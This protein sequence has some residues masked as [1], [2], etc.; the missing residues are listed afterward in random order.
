MKTDNF[1][2]KNRI[3]QLILINLFKKNILLFFLI[4]NFS[5]SSFGIENS[6]LKKVTTVPMF[7]LK[8]A[9]LPNY[10]DECLFYY[11][12]GATNGFDSDYD[13]YK[14]FGPNPA[15]HISIDND[16]LLLVINGIPPVVQSYSTMILTTTNITGSYTITAADVQGLPLGTCVFLK[17]LMTNT[18]TN[19]LLNSYVFNLSNTATTSRFVLTI[20]YNTMP[21]VSSI[22]QPLCNN[23]TAGKFKLAAS[24]NG[25]MN[26][27]WKDTSGNVIK[28]SLGLNSSDSLY[29]LTNGT[30]QVEITS[31]NDAC[32]RNE[33][34][35]NITSVIVPTVNF[36]YSNNIVAGTPSN[37]SPINLSVN[38][39]NYLWNFGDAVGCSNLIQNTYCYSNAGLYQ[40]KL[41][42]IS[43]SGCSDSVTK[44]VEV[45]SL[46]TFIKTIELDGLEIFN[47]G[48]NSYLV[49]AN[50][51]L[52]KELTVSLYNLKGEVVVTESLNNRN[53]MK[54]NFDNLSAE[55]YMLDVLLNNS[56]HR[57]SKVIIQ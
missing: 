25:A 13:A 45:I 14:I 4:L 1:T 51:T 43:N 55:I 56:I 11:Q 26:Y 22:N 44:T 53:E 5:T 30:Y 36:S 23:P 57:T 54:L 29:N 33:V 15:P 42:G 27:N 8:M 38:C 3:V 49:R 32:L 2:S 31:V 20:T 21:I 9:G 16:S 40:V 28:T 24:V 12:V 41:V 10:L 17:D 6:S 47:T 19:L 35:F 37:F 39:S 7:R 50:S 18:T 52:T 46:T 48:N 34:S